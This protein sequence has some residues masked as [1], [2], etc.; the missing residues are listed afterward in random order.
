MLKSYDYHDLAYLIYDSRCLDVFIGV[1]VT[2]CNSQLRNC[3][4]LLQE[5]VVVVHSR[6]EAETED[7]LQQ[8]GTE[9]YKQ[10]HWLRTGFRMG[11]PALL[12]PCAIAMLFYAGIA[13]T[14]LCCCCT[15]RLLPHAATS[16]AQQALLV[17]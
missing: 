14:M 10:R 2:R 15:L 12:L 11:R 8:S 6:A 3:V 5:A 13:P 4:E 1:A 7:L 17:P 9:W 16:L